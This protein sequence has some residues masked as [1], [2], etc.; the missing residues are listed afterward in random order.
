MKTLEPLRTVA[1]SLRSMRKSMDMSQK[2]LARIAGLSQ[3]TIARIETDVEALNPSYDA[4]YKVSEALEIAIAEKH[5]DSFTMKKAEELMHRRIIYADPN[6]TVL[7]AL[8]LA[9]KN[10]LSQLPVIDSR[11]NCVGTLYQKKLLAVATEQKSAL[12]ALKV[13]DIMDPA[14]PQVD[15]STPVR[16][17][18]PL[19]ENWDAVLVADKGKFVGIITLYDL[20][21]IL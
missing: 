11:K 13:K 5:D 14:L 4:L 7:K 10:D 21:N 6:A 2:R 19:M 20:F 15:R 8:E 1:T 3:S 12:S 17:L 9:R 18:R 16:M